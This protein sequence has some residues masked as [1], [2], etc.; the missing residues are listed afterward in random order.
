[1]R[2]LL[3]THVVLWW[4][5]ASERLSSEALNAI[6]A[7]ASEVFVSAVSACEIGQKSAV[8][9]VRIPD[10][11]ERQVMLSEFAELP[12]TIEHGLAAGLLP[13]HHRDSFDRLLIAQARC[14]GLTLVS[15]DRQVAAYDVP[16]LPAGS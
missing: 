2:L 10:D 11:F 7:P 13:L 16:I 5:E 9:K 15:A 3:D 1:M 4:L 6:S 12:I 8:G 14:E